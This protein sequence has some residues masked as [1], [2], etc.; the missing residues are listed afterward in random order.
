MRDFFNGGGPRKK[1]GQFQRILC[2]PFH[3]GEPAGKPIEAALF[4]G[5]SR[6]NRAVAAQVFCGRIAHNV[7]PPV[8]RFKK[9]GRRKGII[10]NNGDAVFMRQRRKHFETYIKIG[11][12][13]PSTGVCA[14]RFADNVEYAAPV[15]RLDV[16]ARRAAAF[17]CYR[18][19][20][21]RKGLKRKPRSRRDSAARSW[22]G[23]PGSRRRRECALICINLAFL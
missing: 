1:G 5:S 12:L 4:H 10:H 15:Q 6:N 20:A 16:R 18:L 13:V 17:V 11:K 14:V 9:A 23:K 8:E 2:V 7:G 3:V 22:S 21:V 19:P